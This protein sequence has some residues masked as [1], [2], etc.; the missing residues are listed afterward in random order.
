MSNDQILFC[1]KAE[2]CFI[3]LVGDLRYNLSPRF[4]NLVKQELCNKTISQFILDLCETEYLDSTNLGILGMIAAGAKNTHHKKPVIIGASKDILT[5]LRSMGFDSLFKI[6]K[7]WNSGDVNYQD[8]VKIEMNKMASREMV[9]ET[10]QAL[11]EMNS[12]NKEKFAPVI[13]AILKKKK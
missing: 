7:D 8:V 4:D 5:I 1:E 13:D 9:L 2:I 3:K 11:A 12:Y 6:E 10:H